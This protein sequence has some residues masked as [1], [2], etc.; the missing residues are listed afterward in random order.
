MRIAVDAAY[1]SDIDLVREVLLR[2]PVGASHVAAERSAEVRF[3]EF[4][5]SGL[6]F[7]LR[8]WID[9]IRRSARLVVDELNCKIYKAF[10]AAGIEIPYSKHDVYIKE[11]PARPSA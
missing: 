10:A 2:C 8:I 1:G 4:G 7:E 5:G 9:R 3:L 11:M 6:R